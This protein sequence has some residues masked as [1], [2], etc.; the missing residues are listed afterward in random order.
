MKKIFLIF[1]FVIIPLISVSAQNNPGKEIRNRDIEWSDFSGKIDETSK[2]DASTYWVT[3][4]SFPSPVFDGNSVR[5]NL[6]VRFFLRA[7]SWFKPNKKSDRLLEH[8]RGHFK[9][10]RICANELEKTINSMSFDKNNY[11]QQVD[12]VY[13]KIIEKYKQI[14]AQYEQDTDHF[15]NVKQQELWNKKL[16]D[17]LNQ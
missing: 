9:I 14:N 16:N 6:T 10:G 8:E 17:L 11:R 15:K 3:T 4:Y 7:D 1:V 12:A 5:V 13:W 2:W